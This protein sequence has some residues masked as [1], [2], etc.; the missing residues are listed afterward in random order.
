MYRSRILLV[1][2]AFML[3]FSGCAS[4]PKIVTQY[5]TRSVFLYPPDDLLAQCLANP[6]FTI[7]QYESA[8][9]AEKEKLTFDYSAHLLNT[10]IVCNKRLDGLRQWKLDKQSIADK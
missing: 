2:I 7:E 9:D 6:P 5:V 4:E 3:L 1:A 10:V 8:G